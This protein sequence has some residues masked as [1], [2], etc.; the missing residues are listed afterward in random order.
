MRRNASL[1][2]LAFIGLLIL[3]WV[4]PR[5]EPPGWGDWAD[6]AW[7]P[8]A[9]LS[10][11]AVEA[12]VLLPYN[13][14]V[15]PCILAVHRHVLLGGEAGRDVLGRP[16]RVFD[17]ALALL[18]VDLLV[19][20]PVT[21]LHLAELSERAIGPWLYALAVLGATVA[22]VAAVICSVRLVL[23]FPAMAL[24]RA[25]AWREG[26]RLTRGHWWA[27]VGS[28][29][30]C[31][32]LI[33]VVVLAEKLIAPAVTGGVAGTLSALVSAAA[34]LVSSAVGAALASALY[35]NYGGMARGARPWG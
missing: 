9:V 19:F 7:A 20:A 35:R 12:A 15:A 31:L 26:W 10:G 17:F 14:I 27:I 6:H 22:I 34:D 23:V 4:E 2:T 18:A 11:L 33:W 32:L 21:G 13:A 8:G 28:L 5:A 30:F 29:L 24:D 1:F 3:E 25:D 16:R